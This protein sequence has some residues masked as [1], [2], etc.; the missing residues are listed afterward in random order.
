[1]AITIEQI[2]RKVGVSSATVS[3]VLNNTQYVNPQ[4]RDAVLKLVQES[5]APPR[6]LG[7]RQKSKAQPAQTGLVEI[8]LIDRFPKPV[9]EPGPDQIT[10]ETAP[11]RLSHIGSFFRHILEGT[12][13]EL[14]RF[15]MRAVVQVTQGLGNPDILSEVNS[16]ENRGVILFGV[17]DDDVPAFVDRCKC[18]VVSFVTWNHRGWPDYVGIDNLEGIRLG[19]DHLR[20]LGHTRIGHVA[21]ELRFSLVFQQ[22]L[23][24][25]KM[26]LAGADLTYRPEWVSEGSCE[27]PEME[28]SI[29]KIL[30]LPDRPT[31][32]LCSFDRAALAVRRAADKLKLRIPEDLSVVGFDDEDV[33]Q[34][35]SPPL[36]SVRVP[37]EQMGR[38]AVALL[39]MRQ[40]RPIKPGEGVSVRVTPTLTIRQSTAAPPTL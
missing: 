36:T 7:R 39:M 12:V 1:M 29:E 37:T 5:G 32:M 16:S 33:A 6:L 30:S 22:R 8:L 23:A 24:A 3:R 2:A 27:L 20:S 10:V 34:L 15:G 11:G 14:R 19:F 4:A 35:F 25:Y 26:F 21:G 17:Y 18:P 13:D 40:Q 9:R 38:S 28:A 31:A